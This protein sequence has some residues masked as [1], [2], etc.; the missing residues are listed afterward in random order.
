MDLG[1]SDAMIGSAC[2][3]GRRWPTAQ[4]SF[5]PL[6]LHAGLQCPCYKE[7]MGGLVNLHPLALL[8]SES[9]CHFISNSL[10]SM[11]NLSIF[12]YQY[13]I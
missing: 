5:F 8:G 4:S 6:S 13:V 1:V 10:T 3:A 7:D 2:M 11:L 12:V 9:S